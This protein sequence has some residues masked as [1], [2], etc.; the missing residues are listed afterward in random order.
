M[1]VLDLKSGIARGRGASP[2]R[3]IDR[4]WRQRRLVRHARAADIDDMRALFDAWPSSTVT[5]ESVQAA[6]NVGAFV[7][8]SGREQALASMP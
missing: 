5:A 6:T 7:N 4:R 8:S 1:F 2:K 3:R